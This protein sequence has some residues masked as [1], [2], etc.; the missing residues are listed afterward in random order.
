VTSEESSVNH[1]EQLLQF[2]TVGAVP[3]GDRQHNRSDE[4]TPGRQRTR[5][6]TTS[7]RSAPFRMPT[8]DEFVRARRGRSRDNETIARNVA[9][10]MAMLRSNKTSS[11]AASRI[12]GSRHSGLMSSFGGSFNDLRHIDDCS[13]RERQATVNFRSPDVSSDRTR[14]RRV[15]D[16]W[17]ITSADQLR[18]GVKRRDHINRRQ[19]VGCDSLSS[20][21]VRRGSSR[22]R[23]HRPPDVNG[24]NSTSDVKQAVDA[25]T[26]FVDDDTSLSSTS[27]DDN[28]AS[29]PRV[30]LADDVTNSHDALPNRF[31]RQSPA[32][33]EEQCNRPV[34]LS[35]FRQLLLRRR[36][37]RE[38]CQSY[39]SFCHAALKLVKIF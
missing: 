33:R 17:A 15:D 2:L 28:S 5:N 32:I 9:D 34:G 25:A 37:G 13:I 29:F 30:K 38:N 14:K 18:S 3:A 36:D 6:N 19:E 1:V 8:F 22:R 11:A 20:L 7:V 39:L 16:M 26:A 24:S 27:G 21:F 10:D 35:N 23:H 31:S 4:V 12:N